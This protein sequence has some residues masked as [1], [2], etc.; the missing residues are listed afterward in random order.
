MAT[1]DEDVAGCLTDLLLPV[2]RYRVAQLGLSASGAFEFYRSR[3]ETNRVFCE[4]ELDLVKSIIREIPQLDEIYEIGCGW[5]QLVFLLAWSGYNA[6]GF[7]IDDRRFSGAEYFRKILCH[8][9][10]SRAKRATILNEFFPPVR[11]PSSN[12]N[13]VIS[14]N[15]VVSNP[16]FVEDQ[17]LWSL[18]RYRYSIINLDRFCRER[19]VSERP[20]F[21]ARVEQTGLRNLG[22]FCDAGQDGQFYL[23]ERAG[24]READ[25]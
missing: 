2:M 23:F 7:E 6:T 12:L 17:I 22:M 11:R 16:Q 25:K 4:Y 3:L 24:S 10:E 5:G 13:L 1:I 8:I 19:Q 15:I 18:P 21:I 9:D 14:T 20:G